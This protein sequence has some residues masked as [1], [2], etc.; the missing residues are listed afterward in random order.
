[1]EEQEGSMS[2]RKT[3]PNLMSCIVHR[4]KVG[5]YLCEL[6]NQETMWSRRGNHLSHLGKIIMCVMHR[7]ARVTVTRLTAF[8]VRDT[9]AWLSVVRVRGQK[10]AGVHVSERRAHRI[11]LPQIPGGTE[12]YQCPR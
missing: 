7:R 8:R 2:E 6:G 3:R 11:R 1:M 9:M 4:G 12:P 5:F 10:W